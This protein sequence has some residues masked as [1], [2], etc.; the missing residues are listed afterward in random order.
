MWELPELDPSLRE[1]LAL[2]PDAFDALVDAFIETV[3]SRPADADF[4]DRAFGYP[5]SRPDGSY[6]LD[7]EAVVAAGELPHDERA[8]LR[9]RPRVPLLAIGSNGAPSALIRKFAHLPDGEQRIL[10]ETGAVANLDIGAVA[11][12]TI[13]GS[14]PA[15]PIESPGTRVRAALVWASPLQLEALTWSELSYWV[16]RLDG[17]PF[18]PDDGEPAVHGYLLYVARWGALRLGGERL[19]L[20]AIPAQG[21]SARAVTQADMLGEV[22]RLWLG[23]DA[24]EHDLL[25]ALAT[26]H[27]ATRRALGPLLRPLAESFAPPGWRALGS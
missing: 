21:R 5:W 22:A 7:G 17:H 25:H 14:F 4:L 2:S 11:S 1:R 9:A 6:V 23:A 24:G 16:G 3:P 26:D 20:A 19:A 18:V 8:E 27:A 12:P 10:V 15:T 13:Y